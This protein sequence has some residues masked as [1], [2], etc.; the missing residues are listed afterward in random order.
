MRAAL[1]LQTEETQQNETDRQE[2]LKKYTKTFMESNNHILK[3]R[4]TTVG[5]DFRV[6]P[7]IVDEN[8]E[9]SKKQPKFVKKLG[10][11]V[12]DKLD[13][14]EYVESERKDESDRMI[15]RGSLTGAMV[16]EQ[17]PQRCY[18]L[19]HNDPYLRLGPFKMEKLLPSPFRMIFH[20]FLTEP[21]IQWLL[22]YSK[23]K[24]STTR[25]R[26]PSN[27]DVKKHDVS[28][29]KVRIV[30]KTT[31]V[32]IPDVIMNEG[33]Q[34]T[35]EGV[36]LPLKD[37]YGYQVVNPELVKLAKKIEVATKLV[38]RGRYSSTEFQVTNYGLSGL[39]E[40][41]I[42]PHGA[43]E[44][45]DVPP[46]RS[47]LYLSG[48][49]IATFM[50]WLNDVPAG[51]GTAYDLIDYE[52]LVT[53]TRGSAA[54]WIDLDRKGFRETRSSHMGCPI[55]KGSKWIL[56]KWVYYYDQFKEYPCGLKPSDDYKPFNDTY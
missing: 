25:E 21:E 54:F 34:I 40:S 8:L 31:Q 44:G 19:H 23:P 7:Y 6:L 36:E 32:F 24:L 15:C 51:G 14:N 28:K 43:I 42:D 37:R 52:Q 50:A 46:Q 49:M 30:A 39:C 48:D 11:Y 26:P 33:A 35:P 29:K 22:D 4:K 38:V 55:L 9:R 13:V 45:V 10:P 41:H 27:K 56:N 1:K 18:F 16:E 3:S 5:E 53:P 47:S 2:Q 20:D 17:G 12:R